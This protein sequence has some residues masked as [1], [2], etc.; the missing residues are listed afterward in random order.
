[1]KEALRKLNVGCGGD[2]RTGW[3]NLDY[4]DNNGANVIFDLER[5]FHGDRISVEDDTYD[6]ILIKNC[7]HVF[8]DPLPILNELVRIC[9]VGGQ[10]EVRTHM[11][12]NV[13][14]INWK[15]GETKSTLMRYAKSSMRQYDSGRGAHGR[16]EVVS[17]EYYA[18]DPVIQK[19]L[20]VWFWILNKIDH[21]LVERTLLMY[22]YPLSVKITYKKV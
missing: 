3:D 22:F 7:L 11:P 13:T 6:Y 12:N 18:I 2:V 1:M 20:G 16:L 10:I 17:S 15:K 19:R 9:K 4:H 21:R 5:L 14:S 8:N